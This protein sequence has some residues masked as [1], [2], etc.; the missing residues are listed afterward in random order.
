MSLLLSFL[1]LSQTAIAQHDIEHKAFEHTE[2]CAAFVTADQAG[3]CD[4]PRTNPILPV[5]LEAHFLLLSIEVFSFERTVYSSRAPP[6][7]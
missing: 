5:E 2:L 3:D 4:L 6:L 1:L 7:A